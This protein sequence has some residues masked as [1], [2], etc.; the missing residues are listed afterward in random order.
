MCILA[1]NDKLTIFIFYAG[2]NSSRSSHYMENQ[3]HIGQMVLK[4]RM[5]DMAKGLLMNLS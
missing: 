3:T 5:Y 2:Y 4:R 1:Q